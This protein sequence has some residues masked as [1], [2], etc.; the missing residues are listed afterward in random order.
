MI[1]PKLQR[2]EIEAQIEELENNLPAH[3]IPPAMIMRL[4][5]LEDKLAQLKIEFSG[6]EHAA[7]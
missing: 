3:S 1:D 2:I 4:E 7:A 6:E 5:E